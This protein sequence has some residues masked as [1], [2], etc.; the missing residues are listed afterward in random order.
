MKLLSTLFVFVI[1]LQS[2]A[3]AQDTI[4]EVYPPK[5]Y[6][7][8]FSFGYAKTFD[9]GTKFNGQIGEY[10]KV[11]PEAIR[12]R[13]AKITFD[14]CVFRRDE[15]AV[16]LGANFESYSYMAM[17]LISTHETAYN[18]DL[19]PEG[20]T[21]TAQLMNNVDFVASGFRFSPYIEYN[22]AFIQDKR[23]KHSA[24]L[25]LNFSSHR[26]ADVSIERYYNQDIANSWYK[27]INNAHPFFQ[28]GGNYGAFDGSEGNK[29][30]NAPKLGRFSSFGVQLHYDFMYVHTNFNDWRVRAY[31]TF[32]STKSTESFRFTNGVGLGLYLH[33][34]AHFP[35]IQKF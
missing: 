12:F 17:D 18:S 27:E 31:Y 21:V 22:Y 26:E 11:N 5:H 32:W 34:G 1:G 25:Q 10:Q 29:N 9:F 2:L 14:Y 3:T 13:T 30:S 4:R 8:P 6:F 33:L 16:N 20:D 24:G 28:A 23:K 7:L 19:N 15:H 35:K